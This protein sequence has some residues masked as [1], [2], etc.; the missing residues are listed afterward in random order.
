MRGILPGRWALIGCLLLTGTGCVEGPVSW[1]PDSSGIL[2]VTE[3]APGTATIHHYDLARKARRVVARV[4]GEAASNLAVLPEG[5]SFALVAKTP[6]GHVLSV[7]GLDGKERH[8]SGVLNFKSGLNGMVGLHW[9][10]KGE[11]L[12][13]GLDD[14]HAWYDPRDSALNRKDGALAWPGLLGSV[15][16]PDGAGYVIHKPAEGYFFR[17]LDGWE[18]HLKGEDPSSEPG[19][20]EFM[21]VPRLAWDGQDLNMQV[22][23]LSPH[24]INTEKGTVARAAPDPRLK[25]MLEGGPK[26]TVVRDLV[27]LEG[28]ELWL[29]TRQR[30]GKKASQQVLAH[31]LKEA[32]SKVLI[33]A[34][35]KV[36]LL[37]A[38]DRKH[39]AIFFEKADGK[40][41]LLIVDRA[42]EVLD[43]LA[44]GKRLSVPPRIVRA[45]GSEE[46][47]KPKPAVKTEYRTYEAAI[48]TI[49]VKSTKA[50]G[51]AWDIFNGYPDIQVTLRHLKSAEAITTPVAE[52]CLEHTFNLLA[53]QVAAGDTLEI[54]V[55]DVD[56]AYND[57]I[58]L[59]RLDLTPAMLEA[60]A[61]DL[62]F[63]QVSSLR[64]KFFPVRTGAR[65]KVEPSPE[66]RGFEDGKVAVRFE[67]RAPST[68]PLRKAERTRDRAIV[69]IHGLRAQV[70]DGSQAY[71][72]YFDSWQ[73]PHGTAA[74]TLARL[75][76]IYGFSYGQN[77]PLDVVSD[78]PG[79]SDGI[80]RLKEMGYKEIILVGHSAGGVVARQFVEDHPHAGVTQVIQVCSPNAGACLAHASF[81]LR[82]PQT[83]FLASLTPQARMAAAA[84]RDRPVPVHVRFCCL[85]GTYGTWGDGALSCY[86]QWPADLQDQGVPAY[87]L[88]V[89]HHN[90]MDAE[91][92]AR[93][94]AEVIA[95]PEDRWEPTAVAHMR[96]ALFE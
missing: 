84:R 93:K 74:A 46:A 64:L 20:V 44:L 89:D 53:G 19:W 82:G 81:L 79:L 87:A 34:C 36:F 1:L 95:S 80:A 31:H 56:L 45:E 15:F 65:L 52:D 26:G 14:S 29:V 11:R 13:L 83:P 41:A 57:H 69:L 90:C 62:T 96:R 6:K 12:L 59:K 10:P 77:E 73:E 54:D 17:D 61:V 72:P 38:P 7:L 39:A 76:D 40:P 30:P 2:F 42:G 16:R 70:L 66:E 50:N 37:P 51:S 32:K 8:R 27:P 18:R 85:V 33:D 35:A 71:R 28:E 24:I 4:E 48:D 23:G 86:T 91:C 47:E 58:G 3:D 25:P 55:W 60:G 92:V 5:G 22:P 68:V 21:P 49:V 67:Q 9:F 94:L 75:G 78:H 63:G 43:E 88:K